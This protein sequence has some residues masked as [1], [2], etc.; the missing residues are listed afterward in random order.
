MHR[1]EQ[2]V[3]LCIPVDFF[4]IFVLSLFLQFWISVSSLIFH[5]IGFAFNTFN[6]CSIFFYQ[7]WYIYC[8]F[9]EILCHTLCL[10][11]ALRWMV[12]HN[13]IWLFFLS[14]K[15]AWL[16]INICIRMNIIKISTSLLNVHLLIPI[17]CTI[18]ALNDTHSFL[19]NWHVGRKCW[20]ANCYKHGI[21]TI[22]PSVS[23]HS[24][25]TSNKNANWTSF[26]RKF[27]RY[28]KNNISGHFIG[29]A[30][31]RNNNQSK[32]HY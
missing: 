29:S 25:R 7:A 27:T 1:S 6:R 26:G 8:L 15:N 9:F 5:L 14:K 19:G 3:S 24:A 23:Y 31:C 4:H 22:E 13:K 28:K 30:K 20:L 10:S 16:T 17:H 32:W 11:F 2:P 21:W 12:S 18:N